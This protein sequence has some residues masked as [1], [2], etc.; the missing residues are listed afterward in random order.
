MKKKEVMKI[1]RY[2]AS[3]IIEVIRSRKRAYDSVFYEMD[4]SITGNPDTY[5]TISWKKPNEK[6]KLD[7]LYI[8]YKGGSGTIQSAVVGAWKDSVDKE[9]LV[10]TVAN[11][12]RLIEAHE[13]EVAA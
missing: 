9:E 7:H 6:C 11:M 3:C 2:E 8:D 1:A 12:I 4:E 5:V 10:N 13:K